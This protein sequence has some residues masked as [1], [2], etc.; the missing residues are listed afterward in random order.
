LAASEVQPLI[1]LAAKYKI[2]AKGF[3]ASQ[4]ICDCALKPPR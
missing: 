2:I 4:M 3:P 1:D